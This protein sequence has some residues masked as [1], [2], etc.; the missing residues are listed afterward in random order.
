MTDEDDTVATARRRV[1][2]AMMNRAASRLDHEQQAVSR[3]RGDLPRL[4][5]LRVAPASL[6]RARVRKWRRG[7]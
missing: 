7:K 2:T 1:C 6:T 3:W 5:R 4:P